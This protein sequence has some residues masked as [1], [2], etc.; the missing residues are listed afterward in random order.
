VIALLHGQFDGLR[1]VSRDG[2]QIDSL[3]LQAQLTASDA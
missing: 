1:G 3:A 2:A